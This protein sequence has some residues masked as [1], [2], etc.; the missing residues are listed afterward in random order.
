[1]TDPLLRVEDLRVEIPT[2]RGVVHAVRGV[3]FSVQS[4]ETFAL[5]G[6]SGSGKT[7]TCRAILRLVHP[8]GRIAGGRVVFEG[9]DLV[10]LSEKE[11]ERIRGN[12]VAMVFQDPMTA[13]NPVL[14]IERQMTEVLPGGGSSASP[15]ARAA[16]LL[17]HVGIPD[18][19]QRLRA[20]PHQL[21]G[22]QRQR[23]ML[24]IA[25]A[26]RPK[27]LL[28]DEPTTALDVTIQAQILRLVMTLQK[29]L[30]MALIL[31]TH[32][33]GVVYQAVDRVAV[34]YAGQVVE[35]APT[36]EL[37]ARPRHPYTIGLIA[38][39]PSV[40]RTRPL[41]PIPGTPP[42]LIALGRGCPFAPRC[43]W[44]ASECREGDIALARVGEDHWSRCLKAN[45]LEALA[46][47]AAIRG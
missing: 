21:S 15:R 1:M 11:L 44:A 22:G 36:A 47:G 10:R 37:F 19:E 35:L 39:V 20:Y 33:L 4:G 45:Q 32:D 6:E 25:L 38:S 23:V 3:S 40:D 34:M 26:R 28:A 12:G 29:E 17:R 27:L 24:A 18:P 16:E 41:A 14:S 8:P 42:D 2:R 7:M 5:V 9:R 43:A 31:V 30:G 13:L 46:G